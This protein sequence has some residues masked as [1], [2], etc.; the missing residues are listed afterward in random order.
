MQQIPNAVLIRL[1]VSQ[2]LL[3]QQI[4]NAVLIRMWVTPCSAGGGNQRFAGTYYLYQEFVHEDGSNS[5]LRND[6]I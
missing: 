6:G 5:F 1:E 4:P 3:M 2:H